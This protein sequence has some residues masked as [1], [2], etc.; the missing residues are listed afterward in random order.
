MVPPVA[1][2]FAPADL[3]GLP[4]R[5]P[6]QPAATNGTPAPDSG[7]GAQAPAQDEPGE[8]AEPGD[9]GA[10]QSGAADPGDSRAS[11]I[12]DD[13][14]RFQLG[15]RAAHGDGLPEPHHGGGTPGPGAEPDGESAP[16]E[17]DGGVG[18]GAGPT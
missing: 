8:A 7:P 6:R 2:R 14:S 5:T 12:R 13:L 16:G 18:T 11:Q 3:S 1:P 9:S 10:S 4:R 15:Q 17:N